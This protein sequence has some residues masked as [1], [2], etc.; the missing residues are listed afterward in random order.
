MQLD[1]ISWLYKYGIY[2]AII[3]GSLILAFLA[4]N[5]FARAQFQKMEDDDKLQAPT[6]EQMDSG[7]TVSDPDDEDDP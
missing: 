6:Y 5:R 1:Y 4:R 7:V 3:L 2:A